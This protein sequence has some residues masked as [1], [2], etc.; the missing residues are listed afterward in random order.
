M[1]Q[2]RFAGTQIY[3]FIYFIFLIGQQVCFHSVRLGFHQ[4]MK[5]IRQIL[6]WYII[7]FN[8]MKIDCLDIM[9]FLKNTRAHFLGRP[10]LLRDD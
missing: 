1:Q 9:I 4:A 2:P 3:L 10:Q 5:E 7:F 8:T 6:C